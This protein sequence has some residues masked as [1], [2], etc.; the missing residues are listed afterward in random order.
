MSIDTH[1]RGGL[2]ISLNIGVIYESGLN[3]YDKLLYFMQQRA[4]VKNEILDWM[5]EIT[6]SENNCKRGY[7]MYIQVPG[8]DLL[9]KHHEHA[10]EFVRRINFY[11]R[12]KGEF[13]VQFYELDSLLSC[14]IEFQGKPG[15]ELLRPMHGTHR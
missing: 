11:S 14:W 1:L 2:L 3:G 8:Q 6:F 12:C 4:P 5:D 13:I 9:G 7:T 10:G 15:P